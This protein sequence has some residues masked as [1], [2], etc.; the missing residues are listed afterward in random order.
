MWGLALR[1]LRFRKGGFAAAF[2]ALL[3]GA[4]L[5]LACA[6][7]M[8]TG[9]RS[10]AEPER[11]AAA[12]I[13]VT[14]DRN[15]DL[16][17]TE[18]V[19]SED[20]DPDSGW[21]SERVAIDAGL[22]SD[23]EAVSGVDHAVPEI[24]VPATILNDG[25]PL[26]GV[27]PSEGHN[28]ASA[29][30]APYTL[31]AGSAPGGPGEVVLASVLAGPAGIGVGDRV[32]IA[33]DGTVEQFTVTGIADGA[34]R[35]GS[36]FFDDSDAQRLY[37]KPGEV[38]SFG[39]IPTTGTGVA[40]LQDRLDLALEDDAAVTLS[41]DDRGQLEFPGV[42]E[43][44][45]NLIVMAGVFGGMSIMVAMFVVASTLGLSI[46]QR[47]RE[48]ALLRAVGTT[49]GQLRRMVLGEALVVSVFASALAIVPGM[50][51]G[52][53]LFETLASNGIAPQE[54]EFHQG[55]IPMVVA[56][57]SGI[58]T[59]VGAAFIAGR[60]AALT[61]PT[62]ALADASMQQRW[63]S[64]PRA[65]IAV[66]CLGGGLALTIVTMAVMTGP[67]AGSTAGPTVMLW[68]IGLALL[69]PGIT[70]VMTALLRWPL[71]SFTGMA[72]WL[73]ML[74]AKVRKVR[75]AAAIAPIMLVTGLSTGMI[76]LQT[77]TVEAAKQEFD[78]NLRAD[79]VLTSPIGVSPDVVD[80]VTQLP[81]VAGASGFV[82]SQGFVTSPYDD[83]QDDEGIPL[84]GVTAA[85]AEATTAVDV[86]AGSLADLR[87]DTVA[88][89]V[90]HATDI[91]V[92]VGDRI[93]MRLG[94]GAE[95]D[96]TVVALVTGTRTFESFLLPADL[97]AAH[98][99]AGL[100][101]EILVRAASGTDASG[102][103]A[104]LQDLA[105]QHPGM[106]VADRAALAAAHEDG[107]EVGLWI[108]FLMVGMIVGYTVIAV[109]NTLVLAT[110]ERRREY[111]LQRLIGSTRAQVMRM[112]GVEGILITIAGVILG[113]IV[114]MSSLLPFSM[115]VSDSPMLAGP[116][117]IY[118]AVVAGA[119]VL[120]M[121]GTLI[122]T[123][124]ALRTRPA[125]VVATV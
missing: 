31:S 67:V 72:G 106:R 48:M 104:G 27:P 54:V 124:F 91:G 14:A 101:T 24:N 73:A 19:D 58:L 116:L 74:N 84:Q 108:N 82:T 85:G 111:A 114:A 61:R 11:L 35:T 117:W 120:T 3:F 50:L 9:I 78:A 40:E 25:Q 107:Q 32:E 18:P 38:D 100:V 79:A 97:L 99:D 39:V 83:S 4:T 62:E 110:T 77:T 47:Q 6:G 20:Y 49:P 1:T 63:L 42:S 36:I 52:R 46:Q 23:I 30:L 41:G 59:A 105:A 121:A 81:G 21:L 65:I 60:R 57:G 103:A 115:V 16:P 76:Y 22:A 43:G 90:D 80:E 95:V 56:A 69:G 2:I 96:L 98:T 102:L 92:D 87:G 71:R 55:W 8:E 5:V 15:F 29:E 86:I 88:L 45:E 17:T 118:L 51:V 122:P 66:L 64:W 75:L 7:L 68:A 26:A 109:V 93:G 37:G 34:V 123:W 10:A 28:W 13:L 125:E 33:V 70:R 12:P 89:P 94:D 112:A 53:W 113:T 119:G 44:G